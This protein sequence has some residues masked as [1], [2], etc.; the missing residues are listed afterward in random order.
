MNPYFNQTN[1]NI[2]W[3]K[4]SWNPVTDCKHGCKY[5]YA[6]D[7]ANR[8]YKEKFEPTFRLYRLKTPFNTQISKE[9]AKEPSIH[10]V[11]VFSMA[12]LFGHWVPREW[13]DKVL[14]VVS[15]TPHMKTKNKDFFYKCDGIGFTFYP[16]QIS[17]GVSLRYWPCIFAPAFRIYIGPFKIWG[18][19][20]FKSR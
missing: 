15:Q 9:R 4:W 11:F 13:I 16:Y 5:C 8:F 6:R 19:V 1:E 7:I 3:A 2:S 14:D 20:S 17:L 12:D 10:N 18:Y